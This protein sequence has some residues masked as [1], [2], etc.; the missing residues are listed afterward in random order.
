MI[1]SKEFISDRIFREF[2]KKVYLKNSEKQLALHL[3]DSV[4]SFT[5][6]GNLHILM[7]SKI[8][9]IPVSSFHNISKIVFVD[10]T[11]LETNPVIHAKK[12]SFAETAE[13]SLRLITFTKLEEL[14]IHGS[15]VEG[16]SSLNSYPKLNTVALFY[17]DIEE[18]PSVASFDC[19]SLKVL[20]CPDYLIDHFTNYSNVRYVFLESCSSD[21]VSAFTNAK[22]LHLTECCLYPLSKLQ[23]LFLSGCPLINEV[24]TT[25]FPSVSSIV[26]TFQ[27]SL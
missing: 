26:G 5:N 10:C 15:T 17:C 13:V 4:T 7:L 16:L 25:D 14:F 21:L 1:K 11:F 6:I 18:L 27:N 19:H 8:Q 23:D 9:H 24:Y 12:V 3:Y 2:I 22:Y 20:D